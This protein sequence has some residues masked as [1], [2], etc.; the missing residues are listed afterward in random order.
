MPHSYPVVV[1]QGEPCQRHALFA[2][3]SCP[4]GHPLD[5]SCEKCTDWRE[6]ILIDDGARSD[7]VKALLATF[8][9]RQGSEV[10]HTNR[11][12]TAERLVY[13]VPMHYTIA[14]GRN[15]LSVTFS[16]VRSRLIRGDS[17][18]P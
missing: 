12:P 4:P 10:A 14:D 5:P 9:Q 2:S 3:L 7:Q 8:E 15:I 11:P 17:S 13:L 16:Q 6:V 18:T 1:L